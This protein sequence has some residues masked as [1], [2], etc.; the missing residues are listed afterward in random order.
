MLGVLDLYWSFVELRV[1]SAEIRDG[2]DAMNAI[3]RTQR[4][5]GQ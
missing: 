4:S 3:A 2:G 1:R 5:F